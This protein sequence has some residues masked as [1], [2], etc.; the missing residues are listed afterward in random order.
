MTCPNC[1][2]CSHCGRSNTI[3]TGSGYCPTTYP[4]TI[5]YGIPIGGGG[6][7]TTTLVLQDQNLG[8]ATTGAG[9]GGSTSG[10]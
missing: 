7:V 8:S 10:N 4:Y 6:G 2:Y 1:G 5:T 9:G 3:Y